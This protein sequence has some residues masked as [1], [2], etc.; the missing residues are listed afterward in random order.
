MRKLPLILLAVITLAGP[1]LAHAG[2]VVEGSFGKGWQAS[3]EVGRGLG[4]TNFMVAP[5]VGIGEL[6]R[7]EVGFVFDLPQEEVGTNLRIRPMLVLDPPVLPLYGRLIVGFANILEGDRSFEFGGAVGIGGSV[8]GLGLFGEVG[9]VPQAV[10][11]E[12]LWILEG[13]AG[14]YISF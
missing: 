10:S 8:G 14:A 6:L 3:P 11:S 1:A 4:P 13:R 12:Y 7:V 5:G 2:F 9:L